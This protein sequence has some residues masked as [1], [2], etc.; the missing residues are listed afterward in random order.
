MR[1]RFS[2]ILFLIL[3]QAAKPGC[4]V[5][6]APSLDRFEYSQLHL[7]V[8]VRIVLYAPGEQTAVRGARAAFK[9]IATLEDVFSSYRPYSELSRLSTQ[10]E[11]GPVKVSKAL[12]TVMQK[13]QELTCRTGGAFDITVGPYVEL[14]RKARRMHRLP[15]A[16]ELRRADSLV[17][18]Q[19]VRLDQRARTVQLAIPGM[20]LDM[21]GIAK[22]YILDQALAVLKEAGL[23]RALIRAGG[24][25]VVGAPPPGQDGWQ[26]TVA[27]AQPGQDE[28]ELAHAAIA[29][30]GDTQQFVEI[31][32]T[33]YSH[34][35][36]PRTGRGLT[37]RRA[38]TVIAPDGITADS[39]ATALT[40][41]SPEKAER[42][43]RSHPNVS[44]YLRYVTEEGVR[45]GRVIR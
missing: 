28:I 40:V 30:S 42:L 10:A 12:F 31:N 36:D 32:G 26:V 8:Q 22:G 37:S 45:G 27:N 23:P 17:G 20:Q 35:V 24:D 18:W 5:S 25:I 14:W 6:A 41:L 39:Y 15:G 3:V 44:A 13:A 43:V 38:A 21:G 4:A 34:V 11:E 29:S 2:W 9:R 33:R 16:K 1:K 7:G 19:N